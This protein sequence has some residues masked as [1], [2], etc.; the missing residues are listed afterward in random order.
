MLAYDAFPL[1]K[2]P[3]Q[4]SAVDGQ[5]LLHTKTRDK[6]GR[7][8]PQ[9][10][11]VVDQDQNSYPVQ[12]LHRST[13]VCCVLQLCLSLR[14]AV[15]SFETLRLA[16]EKATRIPQG[17]QILMTSEGLQL[18]PDMMFEAITSSGKVQ[19]TTCDAP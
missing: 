15:L 18:K 13:D 14:S 1:L 3:G 10:G 5:G 9:H 8:G 6:S 16:I 17:S 11:V 12:V 19:S 2:H 7:T 4:R